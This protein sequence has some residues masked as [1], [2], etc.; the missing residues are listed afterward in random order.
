MT[1]FQLIWNRQV[2]EFN[3][4]NFFS[5][6]IF[7]FLLQQDAHSENEIA[8]KK[9]EDEERRRQKLEEVREQTKFR[10]TLWVE[11]VTFLSSFFFFFRVSKSNWRR[12]GRRGAKHAMPPRLPE[13]LM[14]LCLR[15]EVAIFMGIAWSRGEALH[16][17][18]S[19]AANHTT[20]CHRTVAA[21]DAN[22]LNWIQVWSQ[23]YETRV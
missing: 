9:K 12:A 4:V 5:Q 21:N 20:H 11:R 15:F 2:Q 23:I 14:I 18:R 16:T 3:S 8:R 1:K 13:S 19:Q 22:S 6:L 10:W 7:W 17:M